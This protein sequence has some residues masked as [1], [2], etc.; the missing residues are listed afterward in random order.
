MTSRTYSC[1]G[2]GA[3]ILARLSESDATFAD[4]CEAAGA[5]G[6]KQR[7]KVFLTL[8]ALRDDAFARR[9][10]PET[11]TITQQGEAVLARLRAGEPVTVGFADA[12]PNV[13]V[14]AAR[15]A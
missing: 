4:L 15:A 7:S 6:D 5:F 10:G 3:Q 8:R 9:N 14:F 1:A 11:Y 13:R 12:V 2:K